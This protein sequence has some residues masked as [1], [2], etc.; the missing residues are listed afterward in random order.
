MNAGS[1]T[2][3]DQTIMKVSEFLRKIGC[4]NKATIKIV[5]K[6]DKFDTGP[7]IEYLDGDTTEETADQ[8]I[9]RAAEYTLQEVN[10]DNNVVFVCGKSRGRINGT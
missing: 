1:R 6:K 3:K 10:F 7:D 2:R 9:E 8:I 5:L 4:I